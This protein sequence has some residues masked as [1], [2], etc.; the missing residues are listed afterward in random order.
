[1]EN[2]RQLC[3]QE[4]SALRDLLERKDPTPQALARF[5][6]QHARLH[7]AQASRGEAP[8]PSWSFEDTILEGL[9]EAQIRLIPPGQEHSIAWILWHL[10]RIEDAA[11]NL[12][13]AGSEQVFDKDQWQG[14]IQSPI[15]HSANE[16]DRQQVEALSAAVDIPALRLYRVEVGKRTRQIVRSLSPE[17]LPQKVDPTRI[18][19]VRLS[20]VIAANASAIIDYWS[21]RTIAGLL[22]MPASRHILSHLNEA[23]E[24]KHRLA[25]IKF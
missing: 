16:I 24:L 11:M 20:G 5:L 14:R 23:F 18:E 15:I 13:V 10:A 9:S 4:Q 21:R 2:V 1:M 17:A 19:R 7:S 3:M 12:L 8:E 25:S 22:L 6:A